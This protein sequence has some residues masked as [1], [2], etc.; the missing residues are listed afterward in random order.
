MQLWA[1]EGFA[2]VDFARRHLA[3]VQPSD[4]LRRLRQGP[5]QPDAAALARLKA[6]LHGRHLQAR[7]IDCQGGDQLT[8]ELEEFLHCVRTG[9]RPRVRGEEGRNALALAMR[10]L[11]SVRSHAWDGGAGGS[12]GPLDL[13]PPRGPLFEAAEGGAAA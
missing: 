13:P 4:E 9:D 6:E 8:R 2:A 12:A 1:P 7:E 11:E 3:L 5:R 10:V